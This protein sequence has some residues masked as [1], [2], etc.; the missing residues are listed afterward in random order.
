MKRKQRANKAHRTVLTKKA[1]IAPIKGKWNNW[2]SLRLSS[3]G[4]SRKVPRMEVLRWALISKPSTWKIARKKKCELFKQRKRR[5]RQ[6]GRFV[7]Q[8]NMQN[9][10]GDNMTLL[11]L[12]SRLQLEREQHL[13]GFSPKLKRKTRW[14]N[15]KKLNRKQQ[16]LKP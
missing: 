8:G 14:A 12:L 11:R 15:Q 2:K 10:K 13:R 7:R 5:E 9:E 6:S 3:L 1:K 16:S 4:E